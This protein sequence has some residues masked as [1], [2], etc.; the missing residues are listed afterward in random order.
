[1]RD[2]IHRLVRGPLSAAASLV[3]AGCELSPLANKIPIGEV[4]IVVLIGDDAG[5][6]ADLYAVPAEGGQVVRLTFTRLQEYAPA[7]HPSGGALAYL[8]RPEG[9]I[10][11]SPAR[12]VVLNLVNL[13]ERDAAVPDSIGVPRRIGWGD[14]GATLYVLGDA[15]I[16][17]SPAPPS[18]MRFAPVDTGASGWAAADSATSILLGTPPIARVVTCAKDCISSAAKPWCVVGSDGQRQELGRVVTP[19]RWGSDSL[20]FIEGDRLLVYSLAGG[21]ARR[22]DWTRAPEKPR[23]VTYWEP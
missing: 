22:I 21:R 7:F 1:V 14:G 9:A 11:S 23:D 10:D 20:A 8:R 4:P 15:G 17:R 18:A 3:I 13:A 19:L 5:G 6:Q 16:A 12:L 2:L